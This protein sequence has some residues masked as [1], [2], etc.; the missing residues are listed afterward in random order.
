MGDLFFRSELL[1]LFSEKVSSEGEEIFFNDLLLRVLKTKRVIAEGKKLF[2]RSELLLLFSKKIRSK[3]GKVF[4][5]YCCCCSTEIHS[6]DKKTFF[7][8]IAV[9]VF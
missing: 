2:F 8:C 7:A 4:F 1:L 9:A 3:G 6:K 5:A